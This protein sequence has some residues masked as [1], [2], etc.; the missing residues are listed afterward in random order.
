M[1]RRVYVK[2]A[3]PC[4]KRVQRESKAENGW[5]QYS[6]KRH[7]G[8]KGMELS[9]SDNTGPRCIIICSLP[10]KLLSGAKHLLKLYLEQSNSKLYFCSLFFFIVCVP[11]LEK[12]KMEKGK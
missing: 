4:S 3:A 11:G 7:V 6:V 1:F 12:R 2:C 10:E 5:K 8:E 9:W